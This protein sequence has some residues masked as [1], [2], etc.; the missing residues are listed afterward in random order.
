[1]KR[2]V[3]TLLKEALALPVTER[4]ALAEA[5]VASLEEHSTEDAETAWK[6]EVERRIAELDEGAVST[7]P[8]AELRQRLF[9]RARRRALKR[10]RDG[11]DLQ[12]TPAEVRD[13]VHRR[14]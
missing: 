12:W 6:A 14:R 2:D 1:M 11:M 5:L 4:A 9:E 10:L 13:D 8:W 3:T 7:I